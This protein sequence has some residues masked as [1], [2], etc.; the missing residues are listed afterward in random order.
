MRLRNATLSASRGI[1]V[2]IRDEEGRKDEVADL[3]AAFNKMVAEI[4]KRQDQLVQSRK[5]ASIGTFTSGIAHELNNPINNISLI[6]ESLLEDEDLSD[7]ERSRLYRDLLEQSERTSEIV[8]NLL[9]FSRT[10]H[11]EVE[12][13][14]LDELVEKTARLIKNELRLHHIRFSKEIREP[15]PSLHLDR[16]GFQ[17]VLLNLFLNAVQA[18]EEGGELRVSLGLTRRGELRMDVRD[19]G[20]GIPLSH[21][22][23]VFDPFF[24]TKKEG[25][26]TGLG[27]S[28]SY[29]IVKKH[30]GRIE[31]RSRPGNG[32]CFSIF[33][34]VEKSRERE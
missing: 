3:V 12:E 25:M 14:R 17:Q 19:T 4:E 15:L 8:K 6:V 32:A 13:V 1:F 16:S 18:M 5:M 23:R 26:G 22:D 33:L 11:S 7:E 24:T 31:V 10:D 21:L 20:K 34:P 2:P 30:G 29:G 27:L 9:D 28:V